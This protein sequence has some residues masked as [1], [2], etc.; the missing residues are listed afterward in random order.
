M[1]PFQDG[2]W[3]YCRQKVDQHH[4]NEELGTVSV[5][6]HYFVQPLYECQVE[7]NH[8]RSVLF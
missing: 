2:L 3:L 5:V 4:I 8:V 6:F 1:S 7:F